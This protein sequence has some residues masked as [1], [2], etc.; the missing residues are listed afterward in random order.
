MT[1][2]NSFLASMKENN[3]RRLWVWVIAVLAFV[4]A[5]PVITAFGLN[6]VSGSN[7]WIWEAV[8]AATAQELIHNKLADAMTSV[9]GF[10]GI[11]FFF[12]SVV[13]VVSGIQGFSYLYSRKKIDFYM[14]MPVKRKKRFL[15][16]WLNGILLYVIPYVAG[17][18]ICL[19]IGAGN[20]AVDKGVV[21]TAFMSFVVHFCVYL[22]IYHLAILAL[23][24]TGNIV[25]TGFGFLVFCLYET[26]VRYMVVGYEQEFFD[27]FP[28]FGSSDI[29]A[30][31][32]PFGLYG[33][34]ATAFELKNT[35]D[36]KY[37]LFLLLFVLVVGGLSYFCYLKRPAEA[38]GKAMTFEITKPFIKILITVPVALVAGLIAFDRVNMD[39]NGAQEGLGWVVFFIVLAVVLGSAL[40]QVIYEFDIKGA[41]HKKRHILIS[42]ALT[43]L[44]FMAFKQDLFG[45]DDYI[46]APDKIESIVFSPENY[47]QGNSSVYFDED[48]RFLSVNGY[49]EKNMYLTNTD[50]LC[51]LIETSMDSYNAMRQWWEENPEIVDESGSRWSYVTVMYRLKSGR[52]VNRALWVDVEDERTG[53]LLDE[54]MGS[55]EFKRGYMIGTSDN[56]NRVLTNEDYKVAATYGNTVYMEKMSDAET[57]E[58]LDIYQRDLKLANFTNVKNSVPVG[59]INLGIT[60]ELPW[61]VYMGASG[62]ARSTRGWDVSLNIYPFYEESVS[63]LKE[64][65]YYMDSQIKLEDIASIQVANDNSEA[66]RKLIEKQQGEQADASV[67]APAAVNTKSAWA[68]SEYDSGMSTRVFADYSEEEDI[69]KIVDCICPQELVTQ[70]WDMGTGLEVDYR[71]TIYFKADSEITKTYGASATYGFSEGQVPEFVREDT[72]YK[73]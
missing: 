44:I 1:S 67:D 15:V 37:L 31:L 18:V 8:D 45:Y 58:F 22:G 39:F 14:G 70:D 6:S 64:H 49:A 63:Y 9:L 47:E 42:G 52:Q 34:L 55:E 2:K 12:S 33:E 65:G 51:E 24:M 28:Y 30:K 69:K 4:L 16:V 60:Q 20:G 71:V 66:A 54:I 61:S 40:I 43:A 25:V 19:L 41:L 72:A 17:I 23:M 57:R 5:L 59:I 50:A 53:E 62:I 10:S 13:A 68:S 29:T 73:E 56:L 27:Y 11:I 3:K 46:P 21:Y 48:G 32:S 35:I 26:I 7:K 38:A 36:I